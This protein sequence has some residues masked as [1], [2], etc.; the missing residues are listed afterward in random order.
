M[1]K[2]TTMTVHCMSLECAKAG[3]HVKDCVAYGE[4]Y[5]HSKRSRLEETKKTNLLTSV[6]RSKTRE[7]KLVKGKYKLN[8]SDGSSVDLE[9]LFR[10]DVGLLSND[11]ATLIKPLLK[12]QSVKQSST[13]A[14]QREL[15]RE[16]NNKINEIIEWLNNWV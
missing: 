14:G 7:K 9:P 16:H 3:R 12:H 1:E 11:P 6:K 2:Q 5:P 10:R 13:L 15:L 8:F 4:K